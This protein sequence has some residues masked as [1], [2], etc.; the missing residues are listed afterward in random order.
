MG[1]EIFTKF[2]FTCG[3]G[4]GLTQVL[5]GLLPLEVA[6]HFY[7][8]STIGASGAIFGLLLA[9]ALYLPAPPDFDVLHLPGPGEILCDDPRRHSTAAGLVGRWGC[10]VHRHF[11]G[12]ATGYLYLKGI[13]INLF[14]E[15]HTVISSGASTAHDASSMCIQAAAA[16]T[17]IGVS[18]SGM[19]FPIHYRPLSS[20]PSAHACAPGTPGCRGRDIAVEA[21]GERYS[22]SGYGPLNGRTCASLG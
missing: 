5:L 10:R 21:R 16:T 15:I 20:H 17:S 7:L 14:S 6:D 1:D 2:Y 22:S 9:Y 11:G 3:I 4:A 18:T 19:S 8:L 12:I 13:R